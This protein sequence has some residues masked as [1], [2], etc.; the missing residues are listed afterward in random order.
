MT[1]CPLEIIGPDVWRAIELA[2]LY[3]KGLPP[4][5][6]G[7]LDQAAIFVQAARAYWADRDAM[8]PA[9]GNRQ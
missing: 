5:A 7:S 8:R 9:E 3:E 2:G 1:G 6:G 4:V